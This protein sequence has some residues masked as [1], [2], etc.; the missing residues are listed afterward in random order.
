MIETTGLMKRRGTTPGDLTERESARIHSRTTGPW[1]SI[2]HRLQAQ[3][4]ALGVVHT[5]FFNGA[6]P[7]STPE[8]QGLDLSQAQLEALG[9]VHTGFFNGAQPESPPEPQ[10]LDL[11]QAAGS[12]GSPG[13]SAHWGFQWS[14]A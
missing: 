7:E 9:V 12:V 14:P 2:S 5:G 10:G 8:P 4:E 3:L 13:S 1:C 6:Q 11:S